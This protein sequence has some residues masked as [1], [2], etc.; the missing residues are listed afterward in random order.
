MSS[1]P[2]SSRNY[3]I[4]LL[5]IIAMLM[6]CLIHVNLWTKVHLVPLSGKEGVYY[7]GMWTE[8][9]CF[10]GVNLYA[11]ITGYVCIHSQWK[12]S[13]Y[14]MLWAQVAF[15]TI[16]LVLLY[17][18]LY[19]DAVNVRGLI[20]MGKLLVVG[21]GYWYFAAYTALFFL[22]P[23]LNPLL[24]SLDRRKFTCLLVL[25]IGWMTAANF[26]QG[27]AFYDKGYNMTW[28]AALYCVGAYLRLYPVRIPVPIVL[29]V[30]VLFP[31]QPVLCVA[32]GLPHGLNYCSPVFAV[33]SI[34]FFLLLSAWKINNRFVQRIIG[35]AAPLSF[36]VY[37]I[38]THPYVWKTLEESC[39][40]FDADLGHP[41]WFTLAVGPAIY[42]GCSFADAVRL[43]IFAWCSVKTCA[44]RTA[45]M[46]QRACSALLNKL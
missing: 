6:V 34:C 7:F 21:S 32:V 36:G 28:L 38:H 23:Y 27:S 39:A 43:R 16:G 41:W 44:E 17:M 2:A 8:S 30:G 22:L 15:Y 25:I 10:I 35:W 31:L 24:L 46:V 4:D 37:L 18:A 11:I 13:R 9:L 14:L 29:L 12:L 45:D 40:R 1:N 5:R 20:G 3:G 19:P 26:F 33:Y 42:L